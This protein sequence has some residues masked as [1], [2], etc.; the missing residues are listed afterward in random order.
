VDAAG[1]FGGGT[2]GI[3]RCRQMIW[4]MRPSANGARICQKRCRAYPTSCGDNWLLLPF[5][6][7]HQHLAAEGG[8]TC[9]VK[10]VRSKQALRIVK[11][12]HLFFHLHHILSS[13]K[14]SNTNNPVR[15]KIKTDGHTCLVAILIQQILNSK[16]HVEAGNGILVKADIFKRQ[17]PQ[18][19]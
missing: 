18:A 11:R 6:K 15:I 2:G 19:F 14:W 12:L 9:I 7:S 13:P 1:P 3:R 10:H 16:Q 8:R 4:L 5:E 17:P